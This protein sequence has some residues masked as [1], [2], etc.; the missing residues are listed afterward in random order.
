MEPPPCD[1]ATLSGG[2]R[3]PLRK[4]LRE[5]C[6][7]VTTATST[8][9]GPPVVQFVRRL[10]S[11]TRDHSS[12]LKGSQ[13]APCRGA[14]ARMPQLPFPIMFSSP[15][16]RCSGVSSSQTCAPYLFPASIMARTHSGLASSVT[17]PGASR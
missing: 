14:R 10:I 11:P 15:R 2:R 9:T 7:E 4:A 3:A 17:T 16:G 6:D 5:R 1:P 12:V 8:N 13:G